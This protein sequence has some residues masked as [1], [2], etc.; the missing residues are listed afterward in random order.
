MTTAEVDAAFQRIDPIRSV[1]RMRDELK[2]LERASRTAVILKAL[3][4]SRF[5]FT[6]SFFAK[7]F[8]VPESDWPVYSPG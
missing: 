3:R 8:E 4:E 5:Q 6:W 2:A 1:S 7:A